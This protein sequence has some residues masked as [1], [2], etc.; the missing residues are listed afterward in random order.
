MVALGWQLAA[1]W[2]LYDQQPAYDGPGKV[3]G[4]VMAGV[5]KPPGGISK[6]GGNIIPEA[7]ACGIS[8]I[9]TAGPFMSLDA[10]DE[11]LPIRKVDSLPAE[12]KYDGDMCLHGPVDL[13]ASGLKD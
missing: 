11:N 10:L 8:P 3:Q 12:G 9:S 7:E 4:L 2:W 13:V 5:D 1:C 6:P